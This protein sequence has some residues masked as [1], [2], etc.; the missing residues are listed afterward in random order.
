MIISTIIGA[1]ILA[2]PLVSAPIGFV[3]ATFALISLWALMTFMGLILLKTTSK[4]E[5]T[6]IADISRKTF[7]GFGQAVTWVV[8]LLLLYSVTVAYMAGVPSLITVFL[9]SVFHISAPQTALTVLF[10]VVFGGI[11]TCGTRATDWA[12]R[13]LF[14]IKFG[15]LLCIIM[16]LLSNVNAD[17]LLAEKSQ[18]SLRA[19]MNVVPIFVSAL[20][21][22]FVIPSLYVYNRD[23]PGRL[24]SAIILGTTIP[25]VLYIGW[26][27]VTLGT[28][29]IISN[30]VEGLVADLFANNS[31]T[32]FAV[33][34]FTNITMLVSFLGVTL[35]LFDF[36]HDGLKRSDTLAGRLQT[37]MVTFIPPFAFAIYSP[38]GFLFALK[39]AGFFSCLLMIVLP[40]IMAYKAK[41]YNRFVLCGLIVVGIAVTLVTAVAITL[42]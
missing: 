16:P 20:G 3:T 22:H 34:G 38:E 29:P 13:L 33:A 14:T 30:S 11:V 17:Y 19:L 4:L 8:T 26:L 40:A 24:Y 27:F 5:A 10:A 28:M 36:L 25:L 15:F 1:G 18:K 2:L 37:A 39:Y 12:N 32:A 9:K 7:G 42:K 35:G 6:S 31:H 21:F 23:R 41:A